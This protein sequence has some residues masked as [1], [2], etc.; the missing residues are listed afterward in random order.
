VMDDLLTK[1][2][3]Y[4]ECCSAAGKYVYEH[5]GATQNIMNY[6]QENRLLIN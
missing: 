3:L 6:I 2:N 1:K 4:D 5:K